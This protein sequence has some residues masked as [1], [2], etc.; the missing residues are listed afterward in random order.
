[1]KNLNTFPIE[2]FLDKARIAI[3]TN[4]KTLNLSIKEVTDLQNSLSVVMTRLAGELDQSSDSGVTE[5]I[6]IKL[7]GGTF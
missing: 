1:M 3:K 5:D 7:N 2:D 6:V 4:Q